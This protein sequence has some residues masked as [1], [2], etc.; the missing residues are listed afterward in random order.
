MEKQVALDLVV[1]EHDTAVRKFGPFHSSHEGL[2]I[3]QEEF[4][5]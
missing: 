4:E 5:S 3:I 2:S 1:L